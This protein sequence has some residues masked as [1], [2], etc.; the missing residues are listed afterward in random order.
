VGGY[1]GDCHYILFA[2]SY[3]GVGKAY[4]GMGA[5]EGN[6]HNFGVYTDGGH[7]QDVHYNV[8]SGECSKPCRYSR[9]C[10]ITTRASA[11]LGGAWQE[12]LSGKYAVL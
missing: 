3:H 6:H 11:R 2:V 4:Q 5:D 12:E 7:I 1:S 10:N 9:D 8:D